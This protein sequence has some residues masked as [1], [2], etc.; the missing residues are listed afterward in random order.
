M[1]SRILV[2]DIWG[3]LGHFKKPYTTTSPLS[4]AFP[5]RPTI[6]GIISAIIGLDKTEYAD[7]FTKKN[8]HIAIRINKP[9][10]KIRISQNLIDTKRAVL[11]SRIRQRTQIRFEYVKDP[12]YRIYFQHNDHLLYQRFKT[13]LQNHESVY[14][15]SLGLS[16]LLANFKFIGEFDLY[17]LENKK[18]V[19]LNSVLPIQLSTDFKIE[20]GKAYFSEDMPI[21]M[22]KQ[23]VV[24][25]FGKF[26]YE[27][28]GMP[29]MAKPDKYFKVE[30]GD[31]ILF[32]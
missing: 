29:V 3:D 8:A 17:E 14:T 6:A 16:E 11:F 7:H 25:Q 2:F 32:L 31:T 30:N 26:F 24:S 4:F 20:T 18:P 27:R 23:R 28:N 10:K 5:P 1:K 21:E 13:C 22:D 9:I 19:L 12:G 15:V